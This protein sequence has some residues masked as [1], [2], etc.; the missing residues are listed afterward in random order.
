MADM[1]SIEWVT[2]PMTMVT[3]F[4]AYERDVHA[5][6]KRLM[7]YFAPQVQQWMV[8]NASWQDR[9]GNLRQSIYAEVEALVYGAAIVFGHSMEYSIYIELGLSGKF[10][11]ILPA[12]DHW[13][14]IIWQ[15]VQALLG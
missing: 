11:I 6:L 4:D 15:A 10:S 7:D 2:D 12:L 9:T 14:P 5:G 3:A 13:S 8:E 1:F